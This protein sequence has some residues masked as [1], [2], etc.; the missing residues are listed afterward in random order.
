MPI[1][2]PD[3]GR[4]RLVQPMQPLAGTFLGEVRN[5]LSEH[6]PAV[7]GEP[8]FAVRARSAMP[9][10]ADVPELLALDVTGRPVVLEV[11]QVVDDAAIVD[12]LRHAGAAAR[13]TSADLARAYHPDPE[14]FASDY[15]AFRD[16]VPFA[17]PSDL[18][19][20]T[21]MILLCSEVAAES[22]D[23]LAAV[24]GPGW[25]V[26]VLQVGVVRGSDGR[27]LLD[28][29]P[30]AEYEPAR[31]AA[32]PTGLRLVQAAAQA[33]VPVP[34]DDERPEQPFI[35][36]QPPT[37]P[38]RSPAA[39]PS[40]PARPAA[41]PDRPVAPAARMSS[42]SLAALMAGVSRPE[43]APL[44]A[45][46]EPNRPLVTRTET[47]DPAPRV[48]AGAAPAGLGSPF[49]TRAEAVAPFFRQLDSALPFGS[50]DVAEPLI[51]SA[52]SPTHVDVPQPLAGPTLRSHAAPP[53]YLTA[54]AALPELAR[55]ASAVRAPAPLVWLRVRRGQ[56]LEA[57]L[58]PDGLIQL[59]DGALFAD[60]DLAAQRAAQSEGVVDGWRMWRLGD[61][62]LT[63]AEVTGR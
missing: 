26:R 52:E 40:T 30:L 57:T 58:R 4:P 33:L 45:L 1:F 11:S 46:A 31:R 42:S 44:P 18:R 10:H 59:A 54:S 14:R 49:L 39:R 9:E 53:E 24:R 27:R 3:S 63:L 29:S 48:E 7:V 34:L 38:G 22:V 56:R 15:A 23:T 62:G 12:A 21:R 19:F 25:P 5:L 16:Q 43:A 47:G 28:V 32:E 6:L 17:R 20:G 60:P 55:L 50:V 61:G 35:P 51:G 2:E 36:T 13:L 37:I 8:L 41:M